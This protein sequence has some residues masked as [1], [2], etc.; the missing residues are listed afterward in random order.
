MLLT[1]ATGL[2]LALTGEFETVFLIQAALGI[3]PILVVTLALF[4]LRRDAPD[5]HRP[6]RAKFYPWLPALVLLLD[7]GMLMAFLAADWTSGLFIVA[8]VAICVPIGLWMRR[9][10]RLNRRVTGAGS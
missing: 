4:K 7:L 5:L 3:V 6:F 9:N 8:A 10:R 1:A 2:V